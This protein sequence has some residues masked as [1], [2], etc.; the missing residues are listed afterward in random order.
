[1]TETEIIGLL[2]K[3]GGIFHADLKTTFSCARK[4]KDG[5]EHGILV[6]IYDSGTE[7]EP[8]V[9]RYRCVAKSSDGKAAGGNPADSIEAALGHVQW[10]K[11]DEINR[12]GESEIALP[13]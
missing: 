12:E 10:Y 7:L 8:G 2:K 6:E 4:R 1:M 11:L 13:T 3:N 5:S 9:K